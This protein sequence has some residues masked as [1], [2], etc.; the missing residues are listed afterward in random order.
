MIE[1]MF[2]DFDIDNDGR[3]VSTVRDIIKYSKLMCIYIY[4]I[5]I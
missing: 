5:V 3:L 2:N 4:I 1:R